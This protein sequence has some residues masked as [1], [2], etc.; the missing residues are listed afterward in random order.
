MKPPRHRMPGSH[1]EQH[2]NRLIMTILVRNEQDILPHMIE[3][4]REQ[5]VDHFI[6]TDNLSE[7]RT[8]D[9]LAHYAAKGWM[10]V[11]QERQ[12]NYDQRA[13][14]TRM[15]HMA[16]A[17]EL[18]AGWIIHS[19]ADEFWLS[20][21]QSL[22]RYFANLSTTVN[23]VRAPRHDFVPLKEESGKWHE[24]MIYRKVVSLNP[25]G[26]LLPPKVAHRTN[27]Q[28]KI[29]QGNHNLSGFDNPVHSNQGIEILHFP[30]RNLAQLENKIAKGGAAYEH[31]TVLPKTVAIGWR[32]LYEQL[33]L[34]GNLRRHFDSIAVTRNQADQLVSKSWLQIDQSVSDFF[35]E[36]T[37]SWNKEG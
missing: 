35:A 37:L 1:S 26:K 7:D 34:D 20:P 25:Q 14:V 12:D 23:I 24:N 22:K 10:T 13:W 3:Y 6:V 17:P 2:T 9:I 8:P 33:K 29:S 21:G 5:G 32:R 4:H 27:P 28:V 31:N 18:N 11:I 19:D 15:A 36:R 16:T 30:V